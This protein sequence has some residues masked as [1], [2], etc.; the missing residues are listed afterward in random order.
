MDY[1]ICRSLR[2]DG[3]LWFSVFLRCVS[4]LSASFQFSHLSVF[5]F[6]CTASS[7]G[8]RRDYSGYVASGLVVSVFAP[9]LLIWLV[10]SI[11]VCSR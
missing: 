2:L 3:N 6:V 7:S 4:S 8:A 11:M 10:W 9:G 5:R 1:P